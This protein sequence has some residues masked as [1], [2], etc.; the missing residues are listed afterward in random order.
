MTI[1]ERALEFVAGHELRME[2]YQPGSATDMVFHIHP[3]GVAEVQA[4]ADGCSFLPDYGNEGQL[5]IGM[6]EAVQ[7][8]RCG[9]SGA[10]QVYAFA[11]RIAPHLNDDAAI[12]RPSSIH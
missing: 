2:A 1:Y 12:R 8:L 9:L 4:G 3:F 10:N 7:P 11:L 5:L 6:A